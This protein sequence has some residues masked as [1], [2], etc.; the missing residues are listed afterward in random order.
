MRRLVLVLSLLAAAS[1]A[2]PAAADTT[3]TGEKKGA[4]FTIVVPTAWNGDSVIY[5]HGYDFDFILDPRD[6]VVKLME[7]NPRFPESFGATYAAGLDM[8]EMMW[9]MAH[10]REP[11]PCLEYAPDQLLRFLPGDLLW[12]LTSPEKWRQLGSWLTFVSPRLRY[13]V[14]SLRDPGPVLGYL[15]ENLS[16]LLNADR[17]AKRFR[18][19]QVRGE[20]P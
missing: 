14:V 16:V 15:L 11:A 12:I 10:G 7:I 18:M 4:F 8:V 17:R 9:E 5:N 13:Q 20:Q 3:I 6:G 19:G 2:L 1:F